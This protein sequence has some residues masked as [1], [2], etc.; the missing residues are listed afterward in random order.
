MLEAAT[1]MSSRGEMKMSLKLMTCGRRTDES[2]ESS[3]T[4]SQTVEVGT[5]I[6]VTKVF[7]ELQF[8]VCPFCEHGGAK[9]LHDFLDGD[10]LVCQLV[11]SRT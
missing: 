7:Q 9:W 8:S 11:A 5:N 10:G 4:I 1:Y 6:F 2:A 3:H